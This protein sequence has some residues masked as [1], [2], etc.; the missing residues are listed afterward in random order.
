MLTGA[1]ACALMAGASAQAQEQQPSDVVTFKAEQGGQRTED[2]VLT[3]R[4][5]VEI[6]F[7]GRTLQADQVRHDPNTETISAEGSVRLFQQ[8]GT[9]GFANSLVFNEALTTGVARNFSARI[10]GNGTIAADSLIQRDENFA[11]MN[12]AIFTQCDCEDDQGNPKT[13]TWSIEAEKVV[14]DEADESINYRN[15]VVRLWGVPV[16]YT[17]FFSHADPTADRRSGLLAPDFSGTKRRGLSYE[18]P[19]LWSIS[20]HQDL[21]VSPQVNTEVNPFLNLAYRKRFYSGRVEA[22]AGGTY[23]RGFNSEGLQFGDNHAKAYILSWGDFAPSPAW[24]WGFTGEAARDRRLFDQYSISL[25]RPDHGLYRADDRRLISQVYAARQ[26][27]RSYFSLAALAFQSLRPLPGPANPFGVFPLEDNDVLPIVA[28]LGEFRYE[29]EGAV[30]GGRLRLGA[31]SA[32]IARDESP[33]IPGWPGIDSRRATAQADWRRAVTLRSG[34]RVEPFA[35]LR[36]D[37]YSTADL[38][39]ND[40]SARSSARGIPTAGVDVSWPF[41]RRSGSL[42]TIIEPIVQIALS[43]DTKFDP[44]IP[45]E[46]SLAFDFDETNLFEF[47]K[48]PGYDLYEGGRRVN[49]GLVT[50]MDWGADRSLRVLVGQSFRDDNALGFPPQTGL[51]KR[52][53]DWVFGAELKPIAGLA[54]YTRGRLDDFDL[55]R[56]EAGLNA[57]LSR[58][59]GYLRY[60]RAEQDFQGLP[61]EDIEGGGEIF[62]TKN[63]GVVGEGVRDLEQQSWRRRAFGF[64]YRDECLR[65]DLLYQRDNNPLLGPRASSSIVVRLT[66]VTLGDT[67][68]RDYGKR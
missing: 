5:D 23:E 39:L 37:V 21:V 43:P 25:E 54:L 13:P 55:E 47:N 7:R 66:L 18:Q 45:N 46:D 19:V 44:D 49:V 53:S 62:V 42:T 1:A 52:S 3:L 12:S 9:V 11:E 10:P 20:P 8:D 31:S 65:F 6:N 61:R 14:R 67:G 29:P 2:G 22:R 28:P 68:Y 64:V 63:W 59:A 17:P 15:A 48:F 51:N 30:L 32:S 36:G 26:T 4:G 58:G 27:Q 35:H 60:M 56:I 50:S 33:L 24:R 40:Q 57:D 41:V 34:I 16:L 38:T